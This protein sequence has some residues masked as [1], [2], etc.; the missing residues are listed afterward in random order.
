M[1]WSMIFKFGL[2]VIVL[3]SV[4]M[5]YLIHH[6][7][8]DSVHEPPSEDDTS[9]G[10]QSEEIQEISAEEKLRRAELEKKERRWRESIHLAVVV[11]GDR[12]NE[13]IILIKSAILFTKSFIII[14]IFSEQELHSSLQ[15]QIASWPRVIS[16]KFE[17]HLYDISYPDSN[18]EWKMLFKPCASQRLFIPSLLTNVDSVL[19]VDTDILF[20]SPLEEIWFHFT[21]FNNTQLIALAPESEDRQTGWYNRFA[22]HPYYGELGVNSGV[23][24]MN[25]TRLRNSTW[26]PSVMKYYREYKLKITWG[27]QD[28]INIYFHFHPDELY[29][30][31]CEWNYRP[32]HCMYTSVCK[33]ADRSGAYILHGNRRAMQNDKQ[34]AFKAV[35]TA[36]K[37]YEFLQKMKTSLLPTLLKYLET[38]SKTPCGTV[39]HIFSKRVT[40]FINHAD[41]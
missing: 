14:H 38:A 34:P 31:P 36:F 1:R 6:Q 18:N 3:V 37:E 32:D 17:Y 33:G 29:I 21:R 24:L 10:N 16:E 27:D 23:M 39:K 20:L 2:T 28:L 19:Y 15:Q 11:C 35:Y 22:R 5:F 26:L 30:Y 12:G 8:D 4:C 40:Q 13:S 25:L 9:V 7:S 41:Q